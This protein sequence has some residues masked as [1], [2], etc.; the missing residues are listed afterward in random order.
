MKTLTNGC[1]ILD[2]LKFNLEHSKLCDELKITSDIESNIVKEL[3]VEAKKIAS[4]KALLK[5]CNIEKK[6]ND[7]TILGNEQFFSKVIRVNLSN[8]LIAFPYII[9]A[10]TELQKWCESKEDKFVNKISE[11]INQS[12]LIRVHLELQKFIEN[13]FNTGSLARVNPGSTIDWDMKELKKIF[14]I[15]GDPKE[16]IGVSLND[17]FF[18]TPS[19]AYSGIYFHNETNYKNCLMCPGTDCPLRE[20]PYDKN[21]YAENYQNFIG[22]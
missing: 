8:E 3:I 16:L 4:P 6:L 5:K 7:S 2:D 10:G 14:N 13:K 15:L 18:M 20:V 19:K 11:H 21:Y 1:I 22:M 17:N 12:I 9:T